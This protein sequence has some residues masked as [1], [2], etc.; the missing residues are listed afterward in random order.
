MCPWRRYGT[1]EGEYIYFN[2]MMIFSS[3]WKSNSS[4]LIAKTVQCIS[5]IAALLKKTGTGR[6]A[7]ELKEHVNRVKKA[8]QDRD[9]SRHQAL[10]SGFGLKPEAA[11]ESTVF[12]RFTPILIVVPSSVVENW[13]VSHCFDTSY[14]FVPTRDR[15]CLMHYAIFISLT[16]RMNS[17]LG[18]ISTC[19]FIRVQS[20]R[21]HCKELRTVSILF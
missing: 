7:L 15:Q 11:L 17:I 6:D 1:W 14:K 19:L 13:Q 8:L 4:T 21:K 9:D 2:S 18:D 12:P 16:S 10:L 20:V 5:L 3:A